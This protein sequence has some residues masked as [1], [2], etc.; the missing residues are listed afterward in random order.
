[1]WALATTK[2]SFFKKQQDTK[3][4]LCIHGDHD[5]FTSTNKFVNWCSNHANITDICIDGADHFWVDYED[6][7]VEDIEI[8][9]KQQQLL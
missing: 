5:Q 2:A 6:I 9:R 7:L 4:V 8:W 3:K 1:M